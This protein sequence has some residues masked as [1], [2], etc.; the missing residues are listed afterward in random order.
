MR[1]F[2]L[3]LLAAKALPTGNFFFV[4][5]AAAERAAE[6]LGCDYKFKSIP[7]ERRSKLIENDV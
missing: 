4:S 5:V 3:C 7:M 2:L 1:S 6:M